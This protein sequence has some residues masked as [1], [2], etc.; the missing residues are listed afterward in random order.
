LPPTIENREEP[1]RSATADSPASVPA[2]APRYRRAFFILLLLALVLRIATGLTTWTVNHPDETFQ[3]REPAHHLA[4]GYGI[5][6][7]EYRDGVRSWILPA[8][9]AGVMKA[10]AWSAPG[11]HGYLAGVAIFLSLL[12]LVAVWFA[13]AWGWRRG[14]SGAAIIAGFVAAVWYQ[15]IYFAPRAL[16]EVVASDVMLPGL[17]FATFAPQGRQGKKWLIAAGACLA[18][19]VALRVQLAPAVLVAALIAFHRRS[20]Q[21]WSKVALGAALPVAFAAVVDTITWA[22]PLQSV[23]RYL[24]ANVIAG[25][26][27]FHSTNPWY[28]YFVALAVTVTPIIYFA[29]RGWRGAGLLWAV[30]VATII[31]HSFIGLKVYRFA[32]PALPLFATAAGLGLW[33]AFKP[34][35]ES[36]RRSHL[37]RMAGAMALIAVTSWVWASR[38]AYPAESQTDL[39]AYEWTGLQP[40]A[41]GVGFTGQWSDTGGYT[42]LHRNVP[43]Y[44]TGIPDSVGTYV[45]TSAFNYLVAGEV[46]PNDFSGF[47]KQR[48]WGTTCVYSRPGVCEFDASH[49]LNRLLAA[50][51]E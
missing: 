27:N 15:L 2:A 25:R 7:W 38:M 34:E 36:S 32:Y 33:R 20:I 47:S 28:W 29:I 3:T 40:Q 50:R 23:F 35:A 21:D 10:T 37:V 46:L 8:V 1:S 12:S 4:F 42:Y 30:A 31:S 5:V 16:S 13:Y 17:Y 26:G 6:S 14:G 18:G 39:R 11:S 41:C 44:A 51:G 9:L 45:P 22:Y 19:A 49:E 43:L 24:W 48:C